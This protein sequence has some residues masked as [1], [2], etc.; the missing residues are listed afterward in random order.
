MA[1][2]CPLVIIWESCRLNSETDRLFYFLS[3]QLPQI[4]PKEIT[5]APT[6]GTFLAHSC[7]TGLFPVVLPIF[8]DVI[9]SSQGQ[10]VL[11]LRVDT[12]PHRFAY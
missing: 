5:L 11:L 2:S 6:Q 1:A 7:K 8:T 10:E 12:S 4:M 3:I 9:P